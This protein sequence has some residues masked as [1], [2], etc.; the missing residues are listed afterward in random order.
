[1]DT[2]VAS[3]GASSEAAEDEK[4]DMVCEDGHFIPLVG[5][6]LHLD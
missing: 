5:G 2:L 1:M 3:Q 6:L 4:Q